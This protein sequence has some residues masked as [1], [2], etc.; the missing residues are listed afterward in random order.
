MVFVLVVC[1]LLCVF[2]SFGCMSFLRVVNLYFVWFLINRLFLSL[3]LSFLI[4]V[5][6]DGW[7]IFEVLVVW[8]KL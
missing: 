2:C 5:V 6:R 3:C 4:V 1:V 7:E 8:V